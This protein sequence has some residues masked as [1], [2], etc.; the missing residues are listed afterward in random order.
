MENETKTSASRE[1][2][3]ISGASAA[4]GP[5]TTTSEQRGGQEQEASQEEESEKKKPITKF[6]EEAQPAPF[7]QL[8]KYSSFKDRAFTAIGCAVA[9]VTGFA[10]PTLIVL[11]G[12]LLRKFIVFQSVASELCG[13]QSSAVIPYIYVAQANET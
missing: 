13:N 6:E 12:R 10:M 5:A 3:S 11:M 4:V 1:T 2:S 8:F 9:V 7:L